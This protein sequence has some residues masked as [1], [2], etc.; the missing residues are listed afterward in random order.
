MESSLK[1]HFELDVVFVLLENAIFGV[2]SARS[3]VSDIFF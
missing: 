3:N 1:I 2:N